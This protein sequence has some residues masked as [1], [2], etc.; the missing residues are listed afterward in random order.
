MDRGKSGTKRS[1]LVEASGMPVGLA[2]A[3]ANKNDCK[4]LAETIWSIPIPRP[5]P[6]GEAVQHLCLDKG[7]DLQEMHWIPEAFGL[8][9]HVRARGEEVSE[10]QAGQKARRWP[11][12]RTHPWMNRLR[13]LLTRWAK[14]ATN[15]EATLHCVCGLITYRAASL[16]G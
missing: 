2:V 1:L 15:Y 3:G 16:F 4:L 6:T 12:E 5:E 13:S 7:Y 10:K 11:V 8:V 9:A 14:K